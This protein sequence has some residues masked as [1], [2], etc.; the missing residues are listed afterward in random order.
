MY[1]ALEKARHAVA[2]GQRRAER[3]RQ[4]LSET[5]QLEPLVEVDYVEVADAETLEPLGDLSEG[6]RAVALVAAWVGTTRL[7]DNTMLLE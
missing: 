3:I 6:R 2:L 7:I 4:I 5:L 1:R